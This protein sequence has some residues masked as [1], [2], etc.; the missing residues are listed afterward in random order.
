[1]VIHPSG[2]EWHHSACP[3]PYFQTVYICV[4]VSVSTYVWKHLSA[5]RYLC[6]HGCENTHILCLLPAPS[7][8]QARMEAARQPS[9]ALCDFGQEETGTSTT[10]APRHWALLMQQKPQAPDLG[11]AAV[12]LPCPVARMCLHAA[13]LSLGAGRKDRFRS[14]FAEKHA[15]LITGLEL[16]VGRI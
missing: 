16:I 13:L 11:H 8:L 2:S 3:V 14:M 10:L 5:R 1:M 4:C 9:P 7:L 12:A 15:T 6:V